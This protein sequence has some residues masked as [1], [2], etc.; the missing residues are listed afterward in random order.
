MRLIALRVNGEPPFREAGRSVERGGFQTRGF[1]LLPQQ[2][3]VWRLYRAT[4]T[5]SAAGL[6]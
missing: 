5:T 3:A 4:G 2:L 6:A 1:R